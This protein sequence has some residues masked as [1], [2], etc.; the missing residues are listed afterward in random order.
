MAAAT[1]GLAAGS[2]TLNR[3]FRTVAATIVT[4]MAVLTANPVGAIISKPF[5]VPSMPSC[6]SSAN[7]ASQVTPGANAGR[8]LFH[9]H[10]RVW[11]K[12]LTKLLYS[13]DLMIDMGR[14]DLM[15][16]AHPMWS[17]VTCQGLVANSAQ[18]YA[19]GDDHWQALTGL[20]PQQRRP[21]L[22]RIPWFS[23]DNLRRS[24]F[25]WLA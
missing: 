6:R 24:S 16:T 22:S 18:R 2:P 5:S 25:L 1:S 11:T 15:V 20:G 10:R 7:W 13:Y 4:V 12:V 9:P 14:S 3:L 19:A 17:W 23:R 8:R 21:H